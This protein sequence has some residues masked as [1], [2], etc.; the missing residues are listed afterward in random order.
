VQTHRT[1]QGSDTTGPA[2][3]DTA[4]QSTSGLDEASAERIAKTVN[5]LRGKVSMLFIAHRIPKGLK[6]DR[7]VELKP[8]SR[9]TQVYALQA[10]PASVHVERRLSGIRMHDITALQ[11]SGTSKVSTWRTNFY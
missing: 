9:A 11:G 7:H 10:T 4:G 3:P 2:N 5:S 6:V 1:S 8:S